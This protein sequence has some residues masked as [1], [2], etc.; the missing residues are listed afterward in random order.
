M[1]VLGLLLP[2]GLC[3]AVGL[4]IL[5]ERGDARDA[6]GECAEIREWIVTY[7]E[8][9]RGRL[10]RIIVRDPMSSQSFPRVG[11]WITFPENWVK[12]PRRHD[13]IVRGCQDMEGDSY[14]VELKS[15]SGNW[16]SGSRLVVK[17]LSP[18]WRKISFT[19]LSDPN[20]PSSAVV[21]RIIEI[22][23]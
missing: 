12:A 16:V 1:R 2:I 3:L 19:I 17:K 23:K 13:P 20:D 15:K 11:Y 18:G 7:V 6:K 5:P 14:T 22:P 21:E 8:P 10:V 9:Y 4:S